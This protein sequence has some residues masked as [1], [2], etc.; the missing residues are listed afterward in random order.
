MGVAKMCRELP[1]DV[2]FAVN[3]ER[4]FRAGLFLPRQQ[5]G[6]VGMGGKPIDGVDASLNRDVLTENSHQ[7]GA[8]LSLIHI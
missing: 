3:K 5:F 7:L 4:T 6:F 2:L 8:V 1:H